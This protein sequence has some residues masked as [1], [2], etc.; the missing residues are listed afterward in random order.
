MSV[1]QSTLVVALVEKFPLPED[2]REKGEIVGRLGGKSYMEVAAITENQNEDLKL[3]GDEIDEWYSGAHG[4]EKFVR[5][6]VVLHHEVCTLHAMEEAAKV[7]LKARESKSM[8]EAMA[9][10]KNALILASKTTSTAGGTAAG[11]GVTSAGAST[12]IP[13]VRNEDGKCLFLVKMADQAHMRRSTVFRRLMDG[14][15]E[16]FLVDQ[17]KLL[18]PEVLAKVRNGA[19]ESISDTAAMGSSASWSGEARLQRR[20]S[21]LL[22]SK[23]LTDEKT[24]GLLVGY[25]LP[26]GLVRFRFSDCSVAGEKDLAKNLKDAQTIL[27]AI[28]GQHVADM[29]GPFRAGAWSHL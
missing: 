17:V 8:R 6:W 10:R 28:C 4:P 5:A 22:G 14:D 2:P 7:A 3:D 1:L 26:E 18:L 15:S 19:F 29:F 20:L 11:G 27:S 13:M 21:A 9:I 23:A 24:F 16:V 25:H 12:N